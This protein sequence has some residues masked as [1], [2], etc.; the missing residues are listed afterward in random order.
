MEDEQGA[1]SDLTI[2]ADDSNDSHA[3]YMLSDNSAKC[4]KC[5]ENLW[6]KLKL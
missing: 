1:E 2:P 5:I 4:A 6:S 3:P